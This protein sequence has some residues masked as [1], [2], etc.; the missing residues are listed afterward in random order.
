MSYEASG[1]ID[2]NILNHKKTAV[3]PPAQVCPVSGVAGLVSVSRPGVLSI[4]QYR[5]VRSRPD[6]SSM[7]AQIRPISIKRRSVPL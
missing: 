5:G 4:E 6:Q 3:Q 2:Q 1:N 7:H